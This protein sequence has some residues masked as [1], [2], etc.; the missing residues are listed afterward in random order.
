MKPKLR[1]ILSVA[2]VCTSL[3]TNAQAPAKNS[4]RIILGTDAA[5]SLIPTFYEKGYDQNFLI[6][7]FKLGYEHAFTHNFTMTPNINA[8]YGQIAE[9]SK[10]K[11][12]K[13]NASVKND[14]NYYFD[15]APNLRLTTSLGLGFRKIHS[16]LYWADYIDLTSID[17]VTD[18]SLGYQFGHHFELTT[19]FGFDMNS[20]IGTKDKLFVG[21]NV[22][23]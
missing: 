12:R 15:G 1:F 19:G 6:G 2:A 21:M 16:E 22:L 10:K 23:L 5:I 13:F 9:H 18:V 7:N 20:K 11:T 8:G 17:F 4:G 14:F 3:V